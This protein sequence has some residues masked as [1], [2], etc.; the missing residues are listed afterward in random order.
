MPTLVPLRK[1][2]EA[3]FI[4]SYGPRDGT[5]LRQSC[6]SDQTDLV[7]SRWLHRSHAFRAVGLTVTGEVGA[8]GPSEL[9]QVLPTH[10]FFGWDGV[11][12]RPVSSPASA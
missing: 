1:Y 5:A 9:L 12:L 2:V 6:R 8:R 7:G 3:G 11:Q 10:E 4:L